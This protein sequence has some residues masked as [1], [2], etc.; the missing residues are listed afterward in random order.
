M[1]CWQQI[2]ENSGY[3]S[4]AAISEPQQACGEADQQATKGGT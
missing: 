2:A 4:D 3:A 1:R